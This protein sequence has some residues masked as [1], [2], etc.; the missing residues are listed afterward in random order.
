MVLFLTLQWNGTLSVKIVESGDGWM[1][2]LARVHNVVPGSFLLTSLRNAVQNEF[3][4]SRQDLDE[5][6]LFEIQP[7]LLLA[8][9]VGFN[10][11]NVLQGLKSRLCPSESFS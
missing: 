9:V 2:F 1:N 8:D 5:F 11:A 3:L 4:G 10:E 6:H 7:P